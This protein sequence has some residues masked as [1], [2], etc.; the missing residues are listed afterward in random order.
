MIRYNSDS[1][2]SV[3]EVI[4]E[5]VAEHTGESPE[6][7]PPLYNSVDPDAVD[8]LFQG[9]RSQDLRLEFTYYG[10]SITVESDQTVSIE[11]SG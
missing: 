5:K 10:Y 6:T 3:A 11:E 9:D 4:V 7:L 2:S 1:G 8:K